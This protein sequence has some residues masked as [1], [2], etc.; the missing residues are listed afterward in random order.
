MT[1]DRYRMILLIKKIFQYLN[2]LLYKKYCCLLKMLLT[3][4]IVRQRL[5]EY[6]SYYSVHKC[7]R[8]RYR[9]T[10]CSKTYLIPRL[11]P[12]EAILRSTF[13]SISQANCYAS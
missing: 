11:T 9:N 1:R 13:K 5:I 7:V 12:L 4:D 3:R 10:L 2:F 8:N 6:L